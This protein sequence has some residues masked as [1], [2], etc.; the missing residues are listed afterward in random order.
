VFE[1]LCS[2]VPRYGSP[3]SHYLQML[4]KTMYY[5]QYLLHRGIKQSD[6]GYCAELTELTLGSV[7]GS[8]WGAR[9]SS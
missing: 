7:D 8:E 4:T 6:A 5:F 1:G 2:Q 9:R 3:V